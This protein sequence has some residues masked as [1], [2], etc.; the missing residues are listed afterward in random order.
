MYV[1]SIDR[2]TTTDPV[3]STVDVHTKGTEVKGDG[4]PMDVFK[5]SILLAVAIAASTGGSS[6]AKAV[7]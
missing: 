2:V 3:W 7:A 5:R 6:L 1:T 4:C